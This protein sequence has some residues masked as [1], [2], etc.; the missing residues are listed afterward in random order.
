MW[1]S[2]IATL[3]FCYLAQIACAEPVLQILGETWQA[4]A[5]TTC[6]LTVKVTNPGSDDVQLSGWQLVCH[7]V[8]SAGSPTNAFFTELPNADHTPTAS[9][10][11][12]A[13]STGVVRGGNESLP[14]T[15]FGAQSLAESGEGEAV[16]PDTFNLLH[17][18]LTS[19]DATGTFDIVIQPCIGSDWDSC[20]IDSSLT[21]HP[22]E[23]TAPFGRSPSVIATVVFPAPEPSSGLTL[24]SGAA[25]IILM[26]VGRRIRFFS[27]VS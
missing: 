5:D 17:F 18:N 2:L 12:Q 25:A 3:V 8:P 15:F 4:E 23:I 21:V 20:W 26:G 6:S 14:G 24:L 1:Q 11:F 19:P 22:F 7:I 9:F 16:H 10:V 27:C 13:A